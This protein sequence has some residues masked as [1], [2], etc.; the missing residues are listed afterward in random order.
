MPARKSTSANAAPNPVALVER[1]VHGD[2]FEREKADEE[3]RRLLTTDTDFTAAAARAAELLPEQS[4]KQLLTLLAA[5]NRNP[6]ADWFARIDA[7]FTQATKAKTARD[8]RAAVYILTYLGGCDRWAD[9]FANLHP[10]DL[11]PR[12]WVFANSKDREVANEVEEGISWG[13]RACPDR[14]FAEEFAIKKKLSRVA[15]DWAWIG[16]DTRA[17]LDRMFTAKVISRIKP[18]P[19]TIIYE[20]QHGR[21]ATAHA[22]FE[23]LP[24]GDKVYTA[25]DLVLYGKRIQPVATMIEWLGMLLSSPVAPVRYRAAWAACE[26]ARDFDQD[27]GA[28]LPILGERLDTEKPG[29]D[30]GQA[31]WWSASALAVTAA[32]LPRRREEALRELEPRLTGRATPRN[33]AGYGLGM[34]RILMRDITGLRALLD[35]E[36]AKVGAGALSGVLNSAQHDR[37]LNAQND[38]KPFLNPIKPRIVALARDPRKEVAEVA[39]RVKGWL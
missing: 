3:L 26:R 11:W 20:L 31:L 36:D 6:P 12:L 10:R 28:I 8:R 14:A 17:L 1:L 21:A 5:V 15:S 18:S 22:L 32:Y 39:K 23:R 35:H 29:G 34:A 33:A 27:I 38:R 13:L 2:Y 7:W 9:T 25:Q 37:G 16:E 30:S 4:G 19:F 24:E